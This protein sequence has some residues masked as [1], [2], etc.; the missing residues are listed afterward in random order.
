VHREQK[1]STLKLMEDQAGEY[2]ELPAGPDT[3]G[4]GTLNPL[5]IVSLVLGFLWLFWVGS[6]MAIAFGHVAKRQIDKSR[7]TQ[8]GHDLAVAGLTLGWSAFAL[9]AV[10]IV[11]AL[12]GGGHTT[13]TYPTFSS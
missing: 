6:L 2:V 1:S 12:V 10:G 13:T 4:R 7:G 3:G 9:L 8:R 5:A 11:L